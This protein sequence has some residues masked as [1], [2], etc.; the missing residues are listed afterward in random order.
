MRSE[1]APSETYRDDVIKQRGWILVYLYSWRRAF[2][3]RSLLSTP[4]LLAPT[5]RHVPHHVANLSQ[6]VFLHGPFVERA[7]PW[8]EAF[9]ANSSFCVRFLFNCPGMR[10]YQQAVRS[11]IVALL[12]DRVYAPL[13]RKIGDRLHLACSFRFI[14]VTEPSDFPPNQTRQPLVDVSKSSSILLCEVLT[15]ATHHMRPLNR[16][17]KPSYAYVNL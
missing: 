14:G 9:I 8:V 5:M 12:S 11:P 3:H 2:V 16:Y 15:R 6:Q 4:L 7:N 10:E 17:Q 13:H 1:S